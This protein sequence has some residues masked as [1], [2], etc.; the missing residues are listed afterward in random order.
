MMAFNSTGSN[1]RTYR[2]EATGINTKVNHKYIVDCVDNGNGYDISIYVDGK[3]VAS[4]FF[5]YG[6]IADIVRNSN[7]IGKSNDS[8]ENTPPKMELK[9]FSLTIYGNVSGIPVYRSSIY[10]FD[11]T[12]KDFGHPI[13]IDLKTKAYNL[14]YPQHLKKLK[15]TFIKLIGGDE[16]SELYFELYADGHLVNDPLK[17]TCH[18][19]DDGT[20]VLDYYETDKNLEVNGTLSLLGS[21]VL[22]KTRLDESTYQ[23]IKMIVPKKAKNFSFR[24]YGDSEEFLTIDSFGMVCKLGKVKQ[25]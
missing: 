7:L 10:E 15:H 11:T 2:L 9:S 12:P 1:G 8:N 21:L 13:Y 6:G 18:L 24:I 17:Y 4:S 25:D 19:D 3:V 5:N 22:D 14:N 16:Y 20:I 23:T